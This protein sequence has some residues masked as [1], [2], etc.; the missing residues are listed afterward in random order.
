VILV[1]QSAPAGGGALAES[2]QRLIAYIDTATG[3]PV[4]PSGTNIVVTWHA[5]GIFAL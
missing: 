1:Q 5:S 2:A 4:T 3:L